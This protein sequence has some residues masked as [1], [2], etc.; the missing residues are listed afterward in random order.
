MMEKKNLFPVLLLTVC[1]AR[2]VPN[3]WINEIHYDNAGTDANEFVELIVE[4]PE[5][6]YLGDL[7]LY[8]FNGYDGAPY[9]LDTVDE[10]VTGEREGPFQIYT[11]FQRGIQ[12][13]MEGMILVFKDTLVDILA[14]EGTFTG[15]HEPALGLVFPDIGVHETGSGTASESIYLS[16]APGS[17]WTTGLASP[18]QKNPGQLFSDIE[19]PVELGLFQATPQSGGILLRWK[20]ESETETSCYHIYRNGKRVYSV[21]AGGTTSFPR[22]Y[23]W[24]DKSVFCEGSYRYRLS[25]SGYDGTECDLDSLCIDYKPLFS[26]K[27]PVFKLGLPYPNPFNPVTAVA[28]EVLTDAVISLDLIRL[29]GTRIR[30]IFKGALSPGIYNYSLDCSDLASGHY[31]LCCTTETRK[32]TVPL[33]L[34]K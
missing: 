18:G 32:E 23:S 2:A 16:G 13:D 15:T 11:W 34:L 9:C 1:A 28:L 14:Y 12:N 26:L 4:N 3:A 29:D 20:S 30:Q 8:M 10:F 22:D 17:A 7:A 31:L 6:W 5:A 33:I 21:R 19:T 25:A 27:E 24:M